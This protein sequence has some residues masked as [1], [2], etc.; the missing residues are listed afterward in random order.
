MILLSL[1]CPTV[2][3]KYDY[4]NTFE[5]GSQTS[6][7]KPNP[8]REM[9]FILFLL[10]FSVKKS[11]HDVKLNW[12]STIFISKVSRRIRYVQI[13]FVWFILPEFCHFLPE[14]VHFF[15]FGKATAPL[16]PSWCA[17][18][19]NPISMITKTATSPRFQ[20]G[21][22]PFKSNNFQFPKAKNT[23]QASC[24]ATNTP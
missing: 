7:S 13:E 2:L 21:H 11:D 6:V 17:Y 24:P 20:I 18:V 1:V 10:S 22:S 9:Y 8:K 3:R 16:P 23:N 12:Q 4:W 14:K 15:I 19:T 5:A